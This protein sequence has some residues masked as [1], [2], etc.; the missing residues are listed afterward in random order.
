M[1]N[2]D[3]D[4]NVYLIIPV[5]N[6]KDTTLICLDHLQSTGDMPRYQIVVVDDASTDGTAEAIRS[7]YPMVTVVPGSGDLWWTGAM[8]LGMDYACKQGAEHLFWLNDDCLPEVRTLPLL[9]DYMRTHPD[10][11]VA[12]ACYVTENASS[13]TFLTHNGFRGRQSFA[14]QAGEQIAVEGM[15]GWCAGMPAAVFHKIGAPDVNRF[16]HYSGDDMYTLKATRA[17]FKAILLGDA[18]ANL[19]GQVHPK[20]DFRNYFS[21]NATPA[22]TFRSLFLDKKSPYRLPTQFFRYLE[23]YGKFQGSALFLIKLVSWI[24]KWSKYQLLMQVNPGA[25][26]TGGNS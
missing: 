25:L 4:R 3:R 21:V 23:R 18:R 24:G 14:A 12:P 8:A 26:S 10:S 19:I 22:K 15:S 20:L 5:H 17:G 16:P 1:S 6:R 2:P 11:L 9:L 13:V 7:L